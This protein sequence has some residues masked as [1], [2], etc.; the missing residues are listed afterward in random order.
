MNTG[1]ELI[2]AVE[3]ANVGD[4]SKCISNGVDVDYV[5]WCNTYIVIS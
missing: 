1:W 5:S 3:A 4:V 2:K